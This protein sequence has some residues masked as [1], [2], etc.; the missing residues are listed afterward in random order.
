MANS[1][2]LMCGKRNR[3]SVAICRRCRN[4]AED[5]C[6]Y[7]PTPE[8]IAAECEKIKAEHAEWMLGHSP[9]PDDSPRTRVY[10]TRHLPGI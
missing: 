3:S 2:C 9:P 10:S 7:I 4:L 1:K 6:G 8:E 5:G